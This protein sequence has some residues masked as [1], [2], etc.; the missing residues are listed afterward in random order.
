M[1]DVDPSERRARDRFEKHMRTGPAPERPADYGHQSHRL[2]GEITE[3]IRREDEM[4]TGRVR[5]SVRKQF[6]QAS[7]SD[8]GHAVISDMVDPPAEVGDDVDRAIF[9][10]E[11]LARASRHWRLPHST[12]RGRDREAADAVARENDVRLAAQTADLEVR[13]REQT[14][15]QVAAAVSQ[16]Q[17]EYPDLSEEDALVMLGLVDEEETAA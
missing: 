4:A 8:L 10:N 7:E 2:L 1:S 11:M 17:S 6:E 13:A 14:A 16:L 12:L 15:A 9:G 3:G 5:L